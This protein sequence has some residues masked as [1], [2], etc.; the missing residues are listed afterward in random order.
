L[1]ARRSLTHERGLPRAGGGGDDGARLK[2]ES[3]EGAMHPGERS[4]AMLK[5]GGCLWAENGAGGVGNDVT[6]A[7]ELAEGREVLVV[8]EIAG[9]Y[10]GIR[11]R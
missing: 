9:K 1:D 11:C 2:R 3:E 10:R 5:P 6:R 7:A 4:I 8:Q